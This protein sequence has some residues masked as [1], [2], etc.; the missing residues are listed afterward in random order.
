MTKKEIEL[1][2]T[3]CSNNKR[4]IEIDNELRKNV[5]MRDALALYFKDYDPEYVWSTTA[6]N[7]VLATALGTIALKYGLNLSKN[8]TEELF[9]GMAL[10][11]LVFCGIE[12]ASTKKKI[13]NRKQDL[14]NTYNIDDSD[15]PRLKI[16]EKEIRELKKQR[17]MVINQEKSIKKELDKI[18]VLEY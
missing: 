8:L 13:N 18:K 11:W 16:I 10:F 7:L 4:L 2:S 14:E 9:L 15:K 3:S 6:L 12:Y 1:L 5:E 17:K